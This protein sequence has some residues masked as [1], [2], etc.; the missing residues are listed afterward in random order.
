MRTTIY[1]CY[2]ALIF[3]LVF[4]NAIS[5]QDTLKV[6]YENATISEVIL[7]ESETGA[8]TGK[9]EDTSQ[10]KYMYFDTWSNHSPIGILTAIHMDLEVSNFTELDSFIVFAETENSD[11]W[12][13]AFAFSD[14]AAVS[15]PIS[16]DGVAAYNL[17]A[18]SSEGNITGIG[19]VAFTL[20]IKYD[21]SSDAKIALRATGQGEFDE[22]ASRC[23][24]INEDGSISDFVTA[25]DAEVGLAIFPVTEVLG[26]LEELADLELEVNSGN[27]FLSIKSTNTSESFSLSLFSLDGRLLANE[28]LPS[29]GTTKISTHN[30]PSGNYILRASSKN[31]I[32]S[33]QVFVP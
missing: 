17:Y 20:G 27:N 22:A 33:I 14:V 6:H 21:Y 5:A 12:E 18:D 32:G 30:L 31:R 9:G 11:Y 8:I 16:S 4:A 1:S 19:G 2:T 13:K 7:D 29:S 10:G 28:L 24:T 3:F 26:G 23:F 25:Y 15:M